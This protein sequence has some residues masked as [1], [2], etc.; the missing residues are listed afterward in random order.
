MSVSANFG[1][2]SLSSSVC[3]YDYLGL[4]LLGGE[5]RFEFL[6][7]PVISAFIV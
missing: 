5:R 6:L 7:V 4:E 3:L 2:F 1:F